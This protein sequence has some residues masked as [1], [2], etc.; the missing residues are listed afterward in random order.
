MGF[1]HSAYVAYGV[2]VTTS[3]PVRLASEQYDRA[4][5][6]H[7][8]QCPD[9]GPLTAGDYDHDRLFLVT[10]CYEVSLG[11]YDHI[12]PQAHDIKLADWNAQLR[13][14]ADLLGIPADQLSDP[15]WLCIPDVS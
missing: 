12:T 11:T 4:L 1:T 6:Q 5:A 10:Q 7:K 13:T 2:H 3:G 8:R 15:G 14:A 9:V